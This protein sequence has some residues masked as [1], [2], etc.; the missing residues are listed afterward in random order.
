MLTMSWRRGHQRSPGG[1]DP[2]GVDADVVS[3]TWTPTLSW[4]DV[5]LT[6]SWIGVDTNA[7]LEMWTPTLSWISSLQ[8]SKTLGRIES[9]LISLTF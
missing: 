8:R 4:I 6:P 2:G 9:R 7:V 5:L 1:A 3:E